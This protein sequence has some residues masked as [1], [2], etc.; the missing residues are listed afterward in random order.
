MKIQK[1]YGQRLCIRAR[2]VSLAAV[3]DCAPVGV[4]AIFAAS[5]VTLLPLSSA[6]CSRAG[7][8]LVSTSSS[9]APSTSK[10]SCGRMKG[11]LKQS[12]V[13]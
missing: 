4:L 11:D 3:Q 7:P 10:L 12:A 8:G 6:R 2:D 1:C 9:C 13:V 5:S